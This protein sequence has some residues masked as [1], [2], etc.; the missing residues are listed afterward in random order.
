[1]QC[2]SYHFVAVELVWNALDAVAAVIDVI[3]VL[4]IMGAGDSGGGAA[5]IAS[6]AIL[7]L[8]G[9]VSVALFYLCE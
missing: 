6:G 4:V 3:F 1:M 8:V 9:C 7:V 5:A 2:V